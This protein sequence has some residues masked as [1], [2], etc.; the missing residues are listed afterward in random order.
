MTV[1][2]NALQYTHA[3]GTLGH[4]YTSTIQAVRTP[5][6]SPIPRDIRLFSGDAS[7]R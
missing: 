1:I 7:S 5:G 6:N 3:A 2:L 4:R